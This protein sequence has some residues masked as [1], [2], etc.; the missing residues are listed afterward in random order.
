MLLKQGGGVLRLKGCMDTGREHH[1]TQIGLIVAFEILLVLNL[2]GANG[3]GTLP[4]GDGQKLRARYGKVADVSAYRTFYQPYL[5]AKTPTG[6]P[7]R[8]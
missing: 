2:N 4:S 3:G 7:T 6:R 8:A 1:L 5:F